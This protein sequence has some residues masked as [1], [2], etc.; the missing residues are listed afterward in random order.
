MSDFLTAVLAITDSILVR[1][2]A[3]IGLWLLIGVPVAPMY[4]HLRNRGGA[5]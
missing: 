1:V 5:A 3:A 4:G 2:F